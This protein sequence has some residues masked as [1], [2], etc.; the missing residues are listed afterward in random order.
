MKKKD[1]N[2][3]FF[4][5][6]FLRYFILLLSALLFYSP[7]FYNTLLVLTIYP[8]NF[9][10]GI[11]YNSGVSFNTIFIGSKSIEIIDA[12]VAVSA[13][14]LLFALNLLTPNIRKRVYSIIFSFILLLLFNILRISM[15]SMLFINQYAYFE[16]V[17]KVLWYSLN[18]LAVIGIWFLTAYLFKV[19]SIPVYSDFKA[20]INSIKSTNKH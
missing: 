2:Y 6:I 5:G 4:Y 20:V 7:L 13:Y 8:T 9:L 12:C 1:K 10:L 11:F 16:V 19:K 17:H 18:L 3:G 15:L 14:F